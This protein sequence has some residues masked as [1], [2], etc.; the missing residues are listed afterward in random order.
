MEWVIPATV[1]LGGLLAYAALD[2]L[3]SPPRR[4]VLPAH[5]DPTIYAT[6]PA[7]IPGRCVRCE[8][9]NDPDYRYCE[10]CAAELPD[11]GR[12]STA[13]GVRAFDED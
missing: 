3:C 2:R 6:D 1:L 9:R 4:A 5:Y 11:V 12:L 10:N 13:G 7:A 8:T